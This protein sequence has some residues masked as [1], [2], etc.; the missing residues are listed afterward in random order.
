VVEAYEDW[1]DHCCQEHC[2]RRFGQVRLPWVVAEEA[3]KRLKKEGCCRPSF[4]CLRE[5]QR[6]AIKRIVE[7]N[8]RLKSR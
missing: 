3:R 1:P 6:F 7:E 5:R 2:R 8:A 4:L